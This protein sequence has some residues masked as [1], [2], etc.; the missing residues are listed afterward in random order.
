MKKLI[1]VGD[2]FGSNYIE[3]MNSNTPDFRWDLKGDYKTNNEQPKWTY[4]NPFTI[5]PELVAKHLNCSLTNFSS[6]G[7]GNWAIYSLALDSIISEKELEKLI[8]VWSGMN[9]VNFENPDTKDK[10]GPWYK[11]YDGH[12]RDGEYYTELPTPLSPRGNIKKYLRYVYSLQEICK[13]KNI[14][15]HMFQSVHPINRLD[16]HGNPYYSK[17]TNVKMGM[18]LLNS[19]Y[20]DKIDKSIFPDFPGDIT[21]GGSSLSMT[22]LMKTK[23]NLTINKK[24]HHPNEDGQQVLA[25]HVINSIIV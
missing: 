1:V 5:W 23:D 14:D 20:Y 17:D 15:V 16:Y 4:I 21:F 7:L 24:D 11:R 3:Q 25:K 18:D 9:R 19:P 22:D 10:L 2:S 12:Y 8:V 13:S 6:S